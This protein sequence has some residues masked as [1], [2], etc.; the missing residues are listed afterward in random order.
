[1]KKTLKSIIIGSVFALC[2]QTTAFAGEW[3]SDQN[4]WKYKMDNGSFLTYNWHGENGKS[5]FLGS[6]SYLITNSW[7]PHGTWY[8]VGADGAALI[9]TI[10]PDGYVVDS[11]GNCLDSNGKII[12]VTFEETRQYWDNYY[13]NKNNENSVPKAV[14]NSNESKSGWRK[15]EH[16]RWYENE[17]GTYPVSIWK[18]IDGK[19]YYFGADSYLYVGRVTPD[20]YYVDESGAKTNRDTSVGIIPHEYIGLWRNSRGDAFTYTIEELKINADGTADYSFTSKINNNAPL[21]IEYTGYISIDEGGFILK[22][23]DRKE[24]KYVLN[25][26]SGKLVSGNSEFKKVK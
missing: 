19:E 4:G 6:D 17:D 16:G 26:T 20:G 21:V 10:T 8:Y 9:D 23:T 2:I 24:A 11:N 14:E 13:T 25:S 5:Y 18:N 3:V 1:M 7:V 22:G 12:N 15:N